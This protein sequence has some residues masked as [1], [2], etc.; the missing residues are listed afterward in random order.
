[1]YPLRSCELDDERGVVGAR[2]GEDDRGSREQVPRH[3]HLQVGCHEPR[4]ELA[5]GTLVEES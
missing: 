4:S 5:E 2:L 3:R 1:V